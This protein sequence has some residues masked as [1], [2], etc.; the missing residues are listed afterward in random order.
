MEIIDELE[1]V[2]R[3]VYTGALGWLGGGGAMDLSIV[4]RT[5]VI[6]GGRLT[7]HVGGGI[8]ADS[9]AARELEE[10]E[11]KAAAWRAALDG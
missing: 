9:T 4:I 11:E 2:R 6:A 3:G 7:L 1:P 10:T 5:A 8:V